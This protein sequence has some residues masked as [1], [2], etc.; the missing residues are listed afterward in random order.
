PSW[1]YEVDHGATTIWESWDTISPDGVIRPMSFNHYAPGSVDDWLYRR[2]AGIR[3]SSPG[4]RTAVIS[5]DFEIG[6]DHLKA[7]VGTS[8]GRLAV[9]WTR[10]GDAASVVVDVPFGVVATLATAAGSVPLKEGRSAHEVAL[11]PGP[12]VAASSD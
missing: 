5:P 6:V 3:S 9:E 10:A 1:L 8:Y 2:V 11:G 4:Y 7:H 12:A